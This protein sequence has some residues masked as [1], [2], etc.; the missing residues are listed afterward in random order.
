[1]ELNF[2]ES[3]LWVVTL[4][5]VKLFLALV[6]VTELQRSCRVP[7]YFHSPWKLCQG[8]EPDLKQHK[9]PG[10]CR[11]FSF[12]EHLEPWKW[13]KEHTQL[14]PG[15]LYIHVAISSGADQPWVMVSVLA[16]GNQWWGIPCYA[17]Q[18]G[19]PVQGLTILTQGL[20]TW[21][22]DSF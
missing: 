12:S 16:M 6:K 22:M 17:A 3:V 14:I 1:M 11:V 10:S 20:T 13:Q 7:W 5:E 18:A 4:L 8:E 9:N 15:L 21:G 2:P 19:R